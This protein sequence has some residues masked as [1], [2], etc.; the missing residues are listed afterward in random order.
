ADA[1]CRRGIGRM[2]PLH[3]TSVLMAICFCVAVMS[4]AQENSANT[5]STLIDV[6]PDELLAQ[7]PGGNWLSYNGDYTGR[8]YPGLIQLTPSNVNQFRAEGV[9]HSTKSG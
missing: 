4:M 3:R 6:H 5:I 8:R 1:V 9:F 2:C 7:P